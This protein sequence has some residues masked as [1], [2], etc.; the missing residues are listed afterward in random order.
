MKPG[1]ADERSS[2]DANKLNISELAV[3]LWKDF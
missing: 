2:N 1:K 3:I